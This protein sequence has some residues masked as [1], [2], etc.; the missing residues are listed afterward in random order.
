MKDEALEH[1][2]A[3]CDAGQDGPVDLQSFL[4]CL[5]RVGN[6]P[7]QVSVRHLIDAI[8]SRSFGP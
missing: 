5:E 6:S 2:P 4:A 1:E 7:N 3:S 8:G